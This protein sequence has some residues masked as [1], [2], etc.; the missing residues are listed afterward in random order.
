MGLK[1][2]VT[3]ALQ[4]IAG[5]LNKRTERKMAKTA[6]TG[7]LQAQKQGDATN[8]TLTDAEWETVGQSMQD[9]TWK[10]EYVTVSIVS[11]V[12]LIIVGG[13]AQAFGY[14]QLIEGVV[15]SLQAFKEVGLDIGMLVTAVV[16]A[17]LGLK[18]WRM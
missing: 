6:I 9:K 12:N 1:D 10:D 13:V 5:V 11:L 4:P 7:K 15:I 17:A 14:P 8:I 16:F 18:L 3:G 2:I